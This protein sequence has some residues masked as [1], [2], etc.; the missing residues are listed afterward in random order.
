MK[1]LSEQ[2]QDQDRRK[3]LVDDALTVLDREVQEKSGLTG[4]AI[5]GGYKLVQGVR[6]GFVRQVIEALLDDFLA[7]LNPVYAEAAEKKRPADAY[8][9]EKRDQVADAL[10]SVT[11]RRAENAQSGALK[12]AYQKLRPMAKKQVE[13]AAPRLGELLKRH[14]EATA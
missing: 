10:L 12:A 3:A 13:A 2:F 9:V 1:T 14:A 11:D 7:A 6:P 8:L 4:M 5:K